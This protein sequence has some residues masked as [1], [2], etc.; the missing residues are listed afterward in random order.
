MNSF[1]RI[2]VFL[3]NVVSFCKHYSSY[4]FLFNRFEYLM[5]RRPM[6]LNSV[7]LRQNPHNAR[8]WLNRVHLY[9]GNKSKVRFQKFQQ[10]FLKVLVY[11]QFSLFQQMETYEE[12]V[13]TVDPK[14]RTSK[15]SDIWISFAKFYENDH[16]ISNVSFKIF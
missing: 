3:K 11:L 4:Y 16:D 2:N 14:L 9:E 13:K 12:A 1:L 5:D 10:I 7:L 15:L 6:L 8:E